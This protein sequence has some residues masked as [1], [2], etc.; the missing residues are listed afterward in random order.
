M[1]KPGREREMSRDPHLLQPPAKWS[2]WPENQL[3]GEVT[4]APRLIATPVLPRTAEESS[5][6]EK[7][8]R[9]YCF[10]GCD[11]FLMWP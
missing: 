3:V 9:N 6:L 10:S 7:N 2:S 11:G 4:P 8:Q 5:V 1:E